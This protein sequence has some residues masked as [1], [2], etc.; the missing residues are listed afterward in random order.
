MA[1]S[2]DLIA[3]FISCASGSSRRPADGAVA[4]IAPERDR[5]LVGIWEARASGSQPDALVAGD[6][7]ADVADEVARLLP[8]E[9]FGM[10]VAPHQIVRRKLGSCCRQAEHVTIRFRVV[11]PGR[12]VFWPNRVCLRNATLLQFF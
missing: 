10:S 3:A 11:R 1:R 5:R 7:A 2:P 6:L 9:P 4:V 8:V 12:D